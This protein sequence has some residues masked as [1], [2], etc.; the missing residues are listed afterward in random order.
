MAKLSDTHAGP[1][2]QRK[3]MVGFRA[4]VGL[5]IPSTNVAAEI[6]FYTMA[7]KELRSILAAW[8]IRSNWG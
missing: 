7:L 5:L 2:L 1:V 4:R 6:E 8:T 3:P